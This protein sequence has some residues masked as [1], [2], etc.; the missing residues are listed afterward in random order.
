LKEGQ[1][2]PALGE[3]LVSV[4]VSTYAA[5][6]YIRAC[7]EDLEAQTIADKLEIIVIDSGSPENE[8]AIV[9]EFQQSHNN[10][11]YHRTERDTIYA[12]WN[13]AIGLARCKYIAN[14]NC[15]DAH[16]PDA[17]EKLVAALEAHPEADLTYGDYYTTSVP[18]GSFANPSILRHVVH[19]SYH[20]A[21]VMMYCVTGCHP[22]WRKT[23]FD[24]LGL[25]DPSYTAPGDYE[26]LFR[27]V[28]AGL[29]A[30]RVPQ[31]LSLFFQ[32]AEGLSWKSAAQ[33]KKEGDRIL[34][35]YRSQMPIER[36]FKVDPSDAGSVSKAWVT[37]GNLAMQH[38][39]PWLSNFV[40][41]LPYARFCFEQALKADSR[42]V[43]AGKPMVTRMLQQHSR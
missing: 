18:N 4:I 25:F 15:D 22:M 12:A 39:M 14:A 9:E 16:R 17:L 11:S 23:V 3:P 24:K 20:P 2:E 6:K 42:N 43:S 31:P 28:Q 26:F 5:E 10:I 33:T 41:D 40:Q 19:P 21:T 34:G 27:F 29:R 7:L 36:L 32:N 37:L 38:E 1:P 35:K 8:H 30:V 13:R